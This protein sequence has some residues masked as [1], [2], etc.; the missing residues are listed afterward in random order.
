MK[1]LNMGENN[2]TVNLNDDHLAL[3]FG[4]EVDGKP[5]EG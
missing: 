5:K 1:A 4:P 3:L 2:D